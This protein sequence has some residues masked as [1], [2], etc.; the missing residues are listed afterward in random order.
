MGPERFFAVLPM[1]LT[2]YE[3]T[4]LR[5][6]QDSRSYLLQIVKKYL[7]QADLVFFM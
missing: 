1:S 7:R 5:F 3:L 6:A 2:Q 4:S